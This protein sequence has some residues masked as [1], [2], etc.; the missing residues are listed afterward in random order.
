MHQKMHMDNT[1]ERQQIEK[2]QSNHVVVQDVHN[3][4]GLI[5]MGGIK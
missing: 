4:R 5:N 3:Y 1:K 2:R